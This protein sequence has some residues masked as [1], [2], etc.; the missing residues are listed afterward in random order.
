MT[1]RAL[2]LVRRLGPRHPDAGVHTCASDARD[3][4]RARPRRR[5]AG[6]RVHLFTPERARRP[7]GA[8]PGS[9]VEVA[10]ATST[11]RP[12]GPGGERQVHRVPGG[13]MSV[14]ARLLGHL[15]PA[16]MNIYA[17]RG[18]IAVL[19]HAP[20]LAGPGPGGDRGSA[21]ATAVDARR[22]RPL[23]PRRRPG[24]RPGRRGRGPRRRRRPRAC[25]RRSPTGPS[26]LCVCGG[27][28]LAGARLHRRRRVADAGHRAARPGHRRRADAPDRQPGDR[29][30]T[31]TG[32]RRTHRRA[33]RTTPGA[34]ASAPAR[35]PSAAWSAATATTAT[36]AA[37][38][39]SRARVIGTYLHGPLLPKN[40]W[41]ADI[42]IAL[43]AGAPHRRS[44]A[45]PGAPRRPR[46]RRRPERSPC[47]GRGGP[48]RRP[49]PELALRGGAQTAPG[50]GLRRGEPRGSR[51]LDRARRAPGPARSGRRGGRPRGGGGPGRRRAGSGGGDLRR[52]ARPRTRRRGSRP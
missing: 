13:R 31:S 1:P 30:P 14:P 36:T 27:F 20:G 7:A 43:G 11:A 23:L 21:S 26:A 52:P 48:R 16:E 6:H 32:E 34:P 33:S 42:L 10:T 3:A 51:R 28:Q 19:R 47:G 25:A 8:T 9:S 2:G 40:P 18:N 44:A 46:S 41:L 49:G 37:R 22:A 5:C 4:R 50:A 15:Y 35:G 39:A 24:P 29:A 17:D 38:A 45:A 12:V